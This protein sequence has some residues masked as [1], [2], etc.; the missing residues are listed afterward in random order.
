MIYF[1]RF[2][3]VHQFLQL[4]YFYIPKFM[5]INMRFKYQ[6]RNGKSSLIIYYLK[7]LTSRSSFKTIF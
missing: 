4:V 2:Q 1:F 7:V 6:I 3:V 5:I